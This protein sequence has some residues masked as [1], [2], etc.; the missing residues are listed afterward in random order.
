M[1]YNFNGLVSFAWFAI[2][3]ITSVDLCI[4]ILMFGA[5]AA[6]RAKCRSNR[7]IIYN[8]IIFPVAVFFSALLSMSVAVFSF[9]VIINKDFCG[10]RPHESVLNL[11]ANTGL[12]NSSIHFFAQHYMGVSLQEYS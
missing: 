10:E 1:S 8:Y 3:A 7:N 9:L 11:L 2:V 5:R 4:I 6:R 12:E